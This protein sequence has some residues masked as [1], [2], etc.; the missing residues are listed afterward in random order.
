MIHAPCCFNFNIKLYI[1]PYPVHLDVHT[2]TPPSVR[3][4]LSVFK[5]QLDSNL[6]LIVVSVVAG[7][8]VLSIT[9][10]TVGVFGATI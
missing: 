7:A 2:M 4:P 8:E 9:A 6:S 1:L 3:I 10:S 5:N